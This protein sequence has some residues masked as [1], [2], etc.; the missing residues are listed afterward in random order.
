MI[1]DTPWQRLMMGCLKR[2]SR[3]C[4]FSI[5]GG[6][7]GICRFVSMLAVKGWIIKSCFRMEAFRF[8][9]LL[10]FTSWFFFFGNR[11]FWR[12]GDPSFLAGSGFG[13]ANRIKK[14]S[15]PV[16]KM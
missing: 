1:E 13:R 4:R 11:V 7:L 10:R 12:I 2:P 5:R 15:Y 6:R 14:D 16:Q 3:F 8:T 9:S